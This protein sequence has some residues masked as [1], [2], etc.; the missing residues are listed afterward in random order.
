MRRTALSVLTVIFSLMV[1]GGIQ[2]INTHTV[3]ANN[4]DSAVMEE[5]ISDTT[6]K[7]ISQ[8]SSPIIKYY[9]EVV[10]LNAGERLLLSDLDLGVIAKEPKLLVFEYNEE[11]YNKMGEFI[12][13]IKVSDPLTNREE[14]FDVK[15]IVT[16]LTEPKIKGVKSIIV[17]K[18]NDKKS[19]L[20]GI[21][22]TDNVDGDLT[23]KI[24]VFYNPKIYYE[25]QRVIY[26]VTDSA[27]NT[28]KI[29]AIL[30]IE[31]PNVT[32]YSIL[33]MP[34]LDTN[35][36]VV[37]LPY[38]KRVT[39]LGKIWDKKYKQY[40]YKVKYAGKVAY[41]PASN[42]T[43]KNPMIKKV[44]KMMYTNKNVCGMNSHDAKGEGAREV[45]NA[46]DMGCLFFGEKV[47]WIGRIKFYD[48][49]I[50][51]NSR[52]YDVIKYDGTIWYI[53]VNSLSKTKPKPV[54]KK[55][56]KVMYAW[57]SGEVY[58]YSN[59]SSGKIIGKLSYAQK[60]VVIGQDKNTEYY[61]I[62]YKGKVGYVSNDLVFLN[63][64]DNGLIDDNVDP[65]TRW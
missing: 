60:V 49:Y 40:M 59:P 20:N 54:I 38:A 64:P 24:K 55:M 50:D 63:H 18:N 58:S 25:S 35:N 3:Y 16:D 26:S 2:V 22:A 27:G 37:N 15:V 31:K 14:E 21:T 53:S 45:V 43:S 11:P 46:L 6:I 9:N 23:N 61:Q 48:D 29:E 65:A 51:K 12:T 52:T 5:T 39:V 10:Y 30:R 36:K 28:N 4:L 34:I 47:K 41:A 56:N 42:I 8:L 57:R 1:F 44:N 33:A 62:N 32:M 19:I 17:V 7:E 13:K